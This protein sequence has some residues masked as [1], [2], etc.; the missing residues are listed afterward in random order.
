MGLSCKMLPRA[1]RNHLRSWVLG[2]DQNSVLQPSQGPLLPVLRPGGS[3]SLRETRPYP[4]FSFTPGPHSPQEALI[5]QAASASSG[6]R[7]VPLSICFFCCLL[8]LL[9]TPVLASLSP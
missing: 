1:H 5:L 7:P 8:V 3:W 6:P 4:C 9:P 2:Q